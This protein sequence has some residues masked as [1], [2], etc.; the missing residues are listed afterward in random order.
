[1]V[2]LT[3]CWQHFVI[4]ITKQNRKSFPWNAPQWC[5]PVLGSLF[6]LGLWETHF[7][8]QSDTHTGL[9]LWVLLLAQSRDGANHCSFFEPGGYR[10]THVEIQ[11]KTAH[12][13]NIAD[14]LCYGLQQVCF[15]FIGNKHRAHQFNALFTIFIFH[16][17][18]RPCEASCRSVIWALIRRLSEI[19]NAEKKS[20]ANTENFIISTQ[21]IPRQN[22]HNFLHNEKANVFLGQTWVD[23]QWAAQQWTLALGFLAHL[24][25]LLMEKLLICFGPYGRWG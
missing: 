15:V 21:W 16:A 24:H 23:C 9:W 20:S 17:R 5:G 13:Q 2:E 18:A 3:Q 7:L 19:Q 22:P 10:R 25:C 1:M 4:E 11:R 6:L 12:S 14:L 8:D